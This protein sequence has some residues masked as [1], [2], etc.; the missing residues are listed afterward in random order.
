MPISNAG[1]C[2]TNADN[3]K[4]GEYCKFCFKDGVFTDEGITVQE[5]VEKIKMMMKKMGMNDTENIK[6]TALL[7]KLKRWK[8]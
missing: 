6:M 1:D 5:K 8:K 3:S 4:N 7:P 2:G